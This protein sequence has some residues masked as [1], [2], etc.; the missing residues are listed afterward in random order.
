M[1][2]IFFALFAFVASAMSSAET[3]SFSSF[4]MEVE[5]AWAYSIENGNGELVNISHPDGKGT[6]KLQALNAPAPVRREILRNMT[7]VDSSI[8]LNWRAWGDYSGYQ[9]DYS[10]GNSFYR[11]WWLTLDHQVILVVYESTALPTSLEIDSTNK[12]VSSISQTTL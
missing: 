5:D 8:N 1:I 11:Q 9:Y 7:N 6:L 4:R 3:I 10:A 12:M 2:R